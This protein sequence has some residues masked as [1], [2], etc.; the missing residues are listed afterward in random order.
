MSPSPR[1]ETT[2]ELE[3]APALRVE[4]ATKL[5][6][7]F[8]LQL[9]IKELEANAD[10]IK[11]EL[12]AALDESDLNAGVNVEGHGRLKLVYPTT[13]K[14]DPK[15]L[16]AQGITVT[17]LEKATVIRPGR[18]YLKLSSAGVKHEDNSG[19]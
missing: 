2:T 3:I 19:S 17:Q 5:D 14:L 8:A 1:L 12:I 11:T 4:V 9:A 18:A 15:K 6:E 16:I 13:S 10:T 7:F